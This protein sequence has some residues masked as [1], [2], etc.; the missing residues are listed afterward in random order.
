MKNTNYTSHIHIKILTIYI[1]HNTLKQK[2]GHL[3]VT[4]MLGISLPYLKMC[5]SRASISP[6]QN[7]FTHLKG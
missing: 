2:T 3:F 7:F 1:G 5:N 4:L 6:L